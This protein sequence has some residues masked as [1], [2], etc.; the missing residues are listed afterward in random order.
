MNI[1]QRTIVPCSSIIH[2]HLFTR[3]QSQFEMKSVDRQLIKLH[4][5]PYSI[6]ENPSQKRSIRMTKQFAIDDNL[7]SMI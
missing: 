3:A 7:L 6:S 4:K 5:F 2:V 1:L